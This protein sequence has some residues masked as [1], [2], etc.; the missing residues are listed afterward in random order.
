A[1]Q[2]GAP[3]RWPASELERVRGQAG[4]L[5]RARAR[6]QLPRMSGLAVTA[7][8]VAAVLGVG[9]AESFG[10]A[11]LG[12]VAW[13][14]HQIGG[15]TPVV[16]G[17]RAWVRGRHALERELALLGPG[18]R[19]LWDRR[20]HGLPAPTVIAVGPSGTWALWWPEPGL[21]GHADLG[22][23][24]IALGEIGGL[25]AVAHVLGG[26]SA[27]LRTFVHQMACAPLLASR[28]DVLRTAQ[29][30]DTML[31]QEPVGAGL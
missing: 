22:V 9:A 20:V 21:E 15:E 27:G 17:W 25:A 30:L 28:D 12:V 5:A 16:A 7:A 24:A 29:R 19:L 3:P 2:L 6:R 13:W 18:W 31:L 11:V 10:A 14:V 4:A 26:P 8:T 23:A 1:V